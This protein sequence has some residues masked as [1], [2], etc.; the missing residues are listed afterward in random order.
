MPKFRRAGGRHQIRRLLAKY[1]AQG[2]SVHTSHAAAE[3]VVISTNHSIDYILRPIIV[4]S[5]PT[6]PTRELTGVPRDPR[7]AFYALLRQAILHYFY[8]SSTPSPAAAT[9]WP[10][11]FGDIETIHGLV[12]AV[13]NKEEAI[14]IITLD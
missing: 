5:Y 1:Y 13:L 12:R 11:H 14:E 7:L 8:G 3:P 6:L 10:T 4:G 2:Q 9:S